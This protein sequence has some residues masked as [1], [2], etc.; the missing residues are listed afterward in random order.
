VS[1]EY[2]IGRN[3][4]KVKGLTYWHESMV[5]LIGDKVFLRRDPRVWQ[6]AW[7]HRADNEEMLCLATVNSLTPGMA[8]N[9]V[10]NRMVSAAIAR[11]KAV[12]KTTRT[13]AE[14]QALPAP[15]Q[16][17]RAIAMHA[18]PE[19]KPSAKNP[20]GA[21]VKVTAADRALMKHK[22]MTAGNVDAVL[23]GAPEREAP[24]KAGGWWE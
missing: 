17:I 21:A 24:R 3:G 23:D 8:V 12:R 6:K 22:E 18:N 4:V 1:G 19:N 14:A 13:L 7:V 11:V 2:R 20:S 16:I 15:A 5:A 10:D 9:D